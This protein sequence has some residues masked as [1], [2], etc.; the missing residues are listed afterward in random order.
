[1]YKTFLMLCASLAMTNCFAGVDEA[2]TPKIKEV[3]ILTPVVRPGDPLVV[4]LTFEAEGAL[5]TIKYNGFL[6]IEREKTE[7]V[8]MTNLALT[9]FGIDW[10]KTG[11]RTYRGTYTINVPPGAPEG[12]RVLHVGF[13]LTAPDFLTEATY[14]FTVSSEA[15]PVQFTP[16]PALTA[17]E[18]ADRR[19]QEAEFVAAPLAV[20][21]NENFSFK[22][23]ADGRW[24]FT[25]KAHNLPWLSSTAR[26]AFGTAAFVKGE[27]KR[28]F[29][30]TELTVAAAAPGEIKL[31]YQAPD[32]TGSVEFTIAVRADDERALHFSWRQLD[33]EWQLSDLVF[34]ENA[35]GA[36][37]EENAIALIPNCL[38][39]L[40]YAAENLP[41]SLS[42]L[43][44]NSYAGLSMTMAGMV[45][46]DGGILLSWNDVDTA[47]GAERVWGPEL[48]PGTT[49]LNLSLTHPGTSGEFTLVNVGTSDYCR[50]ANAYRPLARE[51]GFL[52]TMREKYGDRPNPIDGFMSYRPM[53][54]RHYVANTRHNK[55]DQDIWQ[56]DFSFADVADTAEYIHDKLGVEKAL[57]VVAGFGNQG[58]DFH[59]DVLPANAEAGGNAGLRDCADRIKK[60]GYLVG[61]H[62]NYQ[63]FYPR[64][65]SWDDNDIIRQ[66]D[67][68]LLKG[69]EWWNGQCYIGTPK[70][71]LKF[72]RRNVPEMKKLFGFNYH[73]LDTIFAVPL[74]RDYNPAAPMSREEDMRGK[75]A[76]CEYVRGQI[77]LVGS[78]EGVEWG[79]PVA[80]YFDSLFMQRVNRR[81]G[82]VVVPLFQ[83]VYGDCVVV[84]Q[85]NRTLTTTPD[86]VLDHLIAAELPQLLFDKQPGCDLSVD[87][88]DAEF[89]NDAVLQLQFGWR[90]KNG[91]PKKDY[92][93]IVHLAKVRGNLGY[94]E[95]ALAGVDVPVP[96]ADWRPD[97]TL[98]TEK[99]NIA[100]DAN[101]DFRYEVLLML[102]DGSER[103]A[104]HDV[105]DMGHAR[106]MIGILDVKD[107]KVTVEPP[108][109]PPESCF[110]RLDSRP[111]LTRTNEAFT[112]NVMNIFTPLMD[113]VRD[114]PMTAH[115]FLTPDRQVEQSEFGDV[116]ITVNY[117]DAPYDTGRFLLPKWGFAVE[118]PDYAACRADR[119]DGVPLTET[120]MLSAAPEKQFFAYGDRQ[121]MALLTRRQTK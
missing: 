1:M 43:P 92:K 5:P 91:L 84:C 87:I 69:G 54:M 23:A 47:L 57:V 82:D 64:A 22:V 13:Y 102:L 96:L 29:P 73:L 101:Q 114:Y 66:P 75:Q 95:S 120:T 7:P 121:A 24:S 98:Q 11:E 33:G 116:R 76:L 50:V 65:A 8:C 9:D 45:R 79:V 38:G 67:G 21:E 49:A 39:V 62:D 68:S 105:V 74:Y 100:V 25:D 42:W 59:P 28:V 60:L 37:G 81:S 56:L 32:G 112:I 12:E 72:A 86:F 40:M 18:L 80:D 35:F 34:P 108:A 14:P 70:A 93:A 17:A 30:I 20:L 77:G 48:L 71:M 94:N 78:E 51:K 44:F 110:T 104:L 15:P 109:A 3:K 115:R 27:E 6:H 26:R 31:H 53:A 106:Y 113:R 97:G 107:G 55:T 89:V 52:K 83:M 118:A 19:R 16:P 90:S 41:T 63:D 10:W 117:G 99:Y 111:E 61:V 4:D 58:Y 36:T 85:G 119:I 46:A 103:I 88:A 2:F